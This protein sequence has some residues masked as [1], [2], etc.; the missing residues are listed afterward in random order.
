ML[1]THSCHSK[2]SYCSTMNSIG[3]G[4]PLS[5]SSLGLAAYP[6]APPDGLAAPAPASS[7][8]SPL[9]ASSG[10]ATGPFRSLI[11]QKERELHDINEYRLRSL[12]EAVRKVRRCSQPGLSPRG[13]VA[14]SSSSSSSSS[15]CKNYGIVAVHYLLSAFCSDLFLTFS[16]SPPP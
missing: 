1:D 12:E 3:D 2:K 14:F 10:A 15:F 9:A 7:T 4:K 16:S 13:P 5:I 6:P 11:A 8:T